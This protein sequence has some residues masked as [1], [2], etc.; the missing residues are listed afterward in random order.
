MT[1]DRKILQNLIKYIDERADGYLRIAVNPKINPDLKS[2]VLALR[3]ELHE[4]MDVII[5]LGYIPDLPKTDQ[6]T[7]AYIIGKEDYGVYTITVE[8]PNEKDAIAKATLAI[9]Y[10][11]GAP[12]KFTILECY[13]EQK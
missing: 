10:Q 11:R 3:R 12:V 7:V 13:K 4:V 8:A 1:D 5:K 6:W 9:P 2:S